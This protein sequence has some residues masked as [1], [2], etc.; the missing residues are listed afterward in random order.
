MTDALVTTQWVADNL[1]TAGYRLIEVDVDTSQYDT[2]HIPG[3][4]AFN[5]QTQLQDQVARDIIS[6]EGIEQ[7]LSDA[8]VS[9]DTHILLYGDNN[10][11]FAAYALWLLQYYGHD[12]VSLIDGGRKKWLAEERPT[13]TDT[14]SYPKTDYNVSK[15]N[16]QY[17]ADRDLIKASLGKPGFSLVDVR[18]PA[19]YS[20]EIIA[21][22][23]MSETAQRAGHI[24]SAANIPWA[25]AVAED[26][27]FK[28]A[29]ELKALYGGK[30]ITGDADEIVAYCRIGERS[31]HSWF[32]LKYIL[33]Y[34]NVKNYDGSWTEWGNL[35]GNPI[36]KGAEA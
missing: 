33:G 23:G 35:I 28:S 31:S 20:G 16:S 10:N 3:A 13:S 6:R 34:Q 11:W 4:I 5:W 27:T 15:I 32:A 2:G 7:L 26:G 30:G 18:S 19:E 24:P 29:E 25:Q 36:K 8:G 22:P 1:N 17:R 12:K 14:P 9:A 21:P